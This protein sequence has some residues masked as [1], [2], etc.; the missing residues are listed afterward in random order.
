M[1]RRIDVLP[2]QIGLLYLGPR[3]W[4]F[5]HTERER[6]YFHWAAVDEAQRIPR[7][8]PYSDTPNGNANRDDEEVANQDLPVSDRPLLNPDA[9]EVSDVTTRDLSGSSPWRDGN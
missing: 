7:M 3:G 5:N 1:N 6:G 4:T 2:M 9:R 8:L